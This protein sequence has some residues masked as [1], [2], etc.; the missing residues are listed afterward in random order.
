MTPEAYIASLIAAITA[1]GGTI[2]FL[3]KTII[4]VKDQRIAD[5]DAVIALMQTAN[6][7]VIADKNAQ[8]MALQAANAAL[9]SKV[10]TALDT[11]GDAIRLVEAGTGVPPRRGQGHTR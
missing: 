4:A 11:L 2:A 9:T 5:K 3:F 8:I 10:D 7:A 1:M 6:Q